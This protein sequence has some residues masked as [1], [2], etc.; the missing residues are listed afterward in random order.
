M[1]HIMKFIWLS[2][3][4]L[5]HPSPHIRGQPT[6]R[7]LVEDKVSWLVARAV[8]VPVGTNGLPYP[9][10]ATLKAGARPDKP[11]TTPAG[12]SGRSLT[13]KMYRPES[14]ISSVS[15]RPSF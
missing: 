2:V 6:G 9:G 4:K 15:G 13:A 10:R 12:E 8:C 1:Y 14:A 11:D 7:S 3:K 5:N